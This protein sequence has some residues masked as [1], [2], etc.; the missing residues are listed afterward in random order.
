M[1]W[2]TRTLEHFGQKHTKLDPYLQ[3]PPL[4]GS[5]NTDR[6][7]HLGGPDDW[8]EEMLCSGPGWQPFFPLS[9]W[10]TAMVLVHYCSHAGPPQPLEYSIQVIK[11]PHTTQSSLKAID[12]HTYPSR[13]IPKEATGRKWYTSVYSSCAM[14]VASLVFPARGTGH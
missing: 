10:I 1:N 11:Y 7:E 5:Q 12:D 2:I 8:E 6:C 13:N 3:T 4:W 9:S 14:E